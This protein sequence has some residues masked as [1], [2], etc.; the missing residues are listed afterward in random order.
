[1]VVSLFRD[2]TLAALRRNAD[3][4]GEPPIRCCV[5][6]ELGG[7]GDNAM[8]FSLG[9]TSY[10]GEKQIKIHLFKYKSFFSVSQLY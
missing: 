9:S 1:M 8:S 6:A 10:I 5:A 3:G 2:L 7:R 4:G